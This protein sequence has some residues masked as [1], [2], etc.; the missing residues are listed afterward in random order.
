MDLAARRAV[1]GKRSQKQQNC[2]QSW[3]TKHDRAEGTTGVSKRRTL[4]RARASATRCEE[5]EEEEEERG[6]RSRRQN[7]KR[8]FLP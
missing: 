4:Y 5:E 3:E 1:V 6:G 8:V 7:V 2:G